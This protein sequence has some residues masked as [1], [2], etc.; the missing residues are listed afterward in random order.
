MVR[1]W[2]RV[3]REVERVDRNLKRSR[4]IG[5]GRRRARQARPTQEC[6][7][8]GRVPK[9]ARIRQAALETRATHDDACVSAHRAARWAERR[10]VRRRVVGIPGLATTKL[11]PVEGHLDSH[12][13][14]V[15]RGVR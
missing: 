15:D 10:D 7:A 1:E 14:V 2:H 6:C 9:A 11:L 13:I 4:A 12:P 8:H 5:V 3:H